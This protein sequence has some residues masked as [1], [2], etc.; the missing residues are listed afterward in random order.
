MLHPRVKGLKAA[1]AS[2][3]TKLPQLPKPSAPPRVTK[4]ATEYAAKLAAAQ[5][6]TPATPALV[7][8]PAV[9]PQAPSHPV[10]HQQVHI[11]HAVKKVAPKIVK[12]S[13]TQR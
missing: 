10:G 13:Y 7:Q 4:H 5:T 8:T 2:T 3:P 11:K 9:H 12:V 6:S 1:K